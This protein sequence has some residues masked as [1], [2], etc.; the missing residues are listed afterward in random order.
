MIERIMRV[1][2]IIPDLGTGGA[3]MVVLTYLRQSKNIPN[4]DMT[5]VSLSNDKGRLYETMVKNEHLPVVYLNQNI[6]DNSVVGRLKQILQIHRF[7]KKY[8]PDVLHLHLSILWMVC[9]AIIGLNIKKKFHTLH[10][11]P[12][13]TSYGKNRIIDKWCYRLF[14]VRPICLN[15]EMCDIAN[16][17]FGRNDALPLPNGINLEL[18]RQNC[19]DAYRNEFG[20]PNNAYV[21]GHVGRFIKVKN[22]PLI[23]RSFA[24]LKKLRP[25]AKLVLVGEGDD[26]E[27]IQILCSDLGVIEDVIFTGA[28][29]DVP[30]LMSMF[31]VFIFPSLYEGLGIVLIEAQA[32]GLRCVVSKHIPH[33][34]F[35]TNK[36]CVIDDDNDVDLWASAL[37]DST[38]PNAKPLMKLEDY[39]TKNV[40]RRLI[41][42]Y[43]G[44]S[45]V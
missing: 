5:L 33:E 29:P 6:S 43:N 8:K 22:H 12:S 23:I 30:Q 18:Y 11:D 45:L 34:A 21:V 24:K 1:L 38:F 13:K 36:V 15:K 31:D 28:R 25:N 14:H 40:M 10:S 27:K 9:L 32:A 17:I 42:Y 2:H 20:I 19:R 39:S 41:S 44:K 26:M 37:S 35:V 4:V 16:R 7:I 3:E